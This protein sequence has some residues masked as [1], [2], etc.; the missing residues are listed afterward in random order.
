DDRLALELDA[1]Q[2]SAVQFLLVADGRVAVAWALER[3]PVDA[4][5]EAEGEMAAEVGRDRR[6]A[7]RDAREHPAEAAV[8]AP[9]RCKRGDVERQAR[10][11]EEGMHDPDPARLA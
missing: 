9:P 10:R 1:D 2:L 8:P 7:E 11:V 6:A 3:R 4:H 5:A